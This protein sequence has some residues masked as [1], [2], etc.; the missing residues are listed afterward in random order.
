LGD[1]AI[2]APEQ[3]VILERDPEK[4]RTIARGYMQHYLKLENYA[5]N[6]LRLGY[7]EADLGG[8]ASD[9][10]VDAIVGWGGI[11][12]IEKRVKEHL[13]AGADH[14]SVQVLTEDPARIPLAELR[15]LAGALL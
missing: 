8:G 1:S 11:E 14:V 6:L 4:A 9:R 3:A 10:L 2:L 15:E 5:N 13:D 7:S 12:A